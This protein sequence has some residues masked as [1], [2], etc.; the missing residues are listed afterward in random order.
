MLEELKERVYRANLD[1]VKHGLVILTWG[2]VSAIDRETSAVVIK[3]SGVAYDTMKAEDMVVVDLDGNVLEGELKPSSDTP[4]HLELYRKFKNIG[5]IVHTHSINA[6]AF[7]Q[8]G[9]PI[10]PLGT[11]HA[12]FAHGAVPV[13]RKLTK[14]EVEAEYELNTGKVIIETFESSGLDAEALPAILVQN[15]APF[16]WGATPEKAVENAVTLEAVAEMALKTLSLNKN[17]AIDCYVLDKHYYRK[18][19]KNAYYGQK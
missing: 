14:E 16:V 19:G 13:S 4:T 7:A 11:T 17:A 3:P 8:A 5:G 2:N 18:H 6:S 15:H 1:L 10:A 9:L 12:D